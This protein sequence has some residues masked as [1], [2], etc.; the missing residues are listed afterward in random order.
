MAPEDQ[1]EIAKLMREALEHSRGYADFF[2]WQPDRDLEEWGVVTSL[3]ESLAAEGRLFFSDL[4][5]RGRPN[6]PP[7]CEALNLNGERLAI[8]VTELVD[9]EAIRQFKKA[10]NERRLVDHAEW[11]REKF[12]TRLQ[13]RV[14]EKDNCFPKLKGSP[15]SGGYIVVVHTDEIGLNLETVSHYLDGH[16]FASPRHILRS[17][18][19]LSYDPSVA[20]CPCFELRLGG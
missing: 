4:T 6:D 10:Q 14:F 20:R 12:L 19:L 1:D 15:Y 13:S 7:D 8:E 3:G 5:S 18:L 9:G 16:S 2:L 17:F 11:T